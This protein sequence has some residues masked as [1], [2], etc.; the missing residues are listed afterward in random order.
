M[1]GQVKL[2]LTFYGG[3]SLAVFEAGIAYELVR[4]AQFSR[5]DDKPTTVPEIHIDVV[6][7]TSAGGLA[8]VQMAAALGGTNTE[9]VLA[10]M[11]SIWANDADIQALLPASDFDKQGFL[12]NERLRQRVRDVLEAAAVDAGPRLQEDL[13]AYLTLTNFSGLR[14]PVILSDQGVQVAFPTTRHVEYEH[15]RAEDVTNPAERERF[16]EAAAITA[17]FPVAFP[18][19]LKTSSSIDEGKPADKA[20]RF[21]Y[22]DGGV[23]DNRPLGRALDSIAEKPAERRL[24]FFID[25]NETWVKPAY[26]ADDVENRKL[27]PAGI[28]FKIG[29]V[30]RSDSIYQDLERVR[31]TNDVCAV[32]TPLSQQVFS[33]AALRE[34]LLAIY[35]EVVQ[36]TFN[37]QVWDLWLL[38]QGCVDEEVKDEWKR[39][40]EQGRFALRARLHELVERLREAGHLS[41]ADA[42]AVRTEIETAAGWTAYYGALRELRALDRRFQ[43]LKYQ[44]WDQHFKHQQR[45]RRSGE[46][47][48]EIPKELQA[49][50]KEA[51]RALAGAAERLGKERAALARELLDGEVIARLT[52]GE[53]TKKEIESLFYDY[54]RSMQVLEALS[55]TRSTPNLSVRRITPFDIYA[56]GTD[57]GTARPLAGGS[58]GAFGG[59]LDKGWRIN[60]FLVGRLAMRAHLRREGLVPD[61]AFSAYQLW[62][63]ERDAQ[64]IGMLVPDS[65][66]ARALAQLASV[67]SSG[68]GFQ[69]DEH[70]PSLLLKGSDL[71]VDMLPGSRL[72]RVVRKLMGSVRRILKM[73]SGQL[74]YSALQVLRPTLL[75]GGWVVWILE[76][77]LRPVP[78]KLG[79]TTKAL[80]DR[81]KWYL[82]VLALGVIIG[83]ALGALIG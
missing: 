61:G 22:V 31:R 28:Y 58:L 51:L 77:T 62:C 26:G 43:Q 33:D 56:D 79:D 23:M 65:E 60:D 34:K 53:E 6:T 4:A 18:P 30:A 82:A 46:S 50:L 35:P 45:I 29:A 10:K 38:V 81:L 74:P 21:V 14:E 7:G 44:L 67:E 41:A 70:K 16:V 37:P 12:D 80:G 47:G 55:G 2:G 63:N 27:D 20:T 42:A 78:H 59:F 71:D 24:F 25:P 11:V 75:A 32:L 1:S 19:A 57:L 54:A 52:V 73:N 13:D 5:R 9:A 36:R 8:A 3:V 83:L 15:F 66:E 39:V 72:A 76:Q 17:G 69:S 64:V 48:G 49:G 68:R 40:G